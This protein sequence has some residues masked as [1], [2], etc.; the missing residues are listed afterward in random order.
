MIIVIR[1]ITRHIGS[2]VRIT[3]QMAIS[4]TSSPIYLLTMPKIP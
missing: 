1:I 2:I 4:E 3:E